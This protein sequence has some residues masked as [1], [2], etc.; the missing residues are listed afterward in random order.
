MQW[1]V[2]AIRNICEGNPTNQEYIARLEKKG[3][4]NMQDL[5]R[6][7]GCEV[8]IGTD[9]RLRLKKAE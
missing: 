5:E 8:S 7:F 3:S 1:S 6:E 9:G 2:W 4:F